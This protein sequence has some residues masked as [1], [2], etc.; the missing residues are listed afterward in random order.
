MTLEWLA[1]LSLGFNRAEYQ[2]GHFE[3][4][5]LEQVHERMRAIGRYVTF[6]ENPF[7]RVAGGGP[8]RGPRSPRT[9]FQQRVRGAGL[10][11]KRPRCGDVRRLGLFERCLYQAA[12]RSEE[13]HALFRMQAMLGEPARSRH[14][15]GAA[16]H[17]RA[18]SSADRPERHAREGIKG[19]VPRSRVPLG[20]LGHAC[21]AL[22]ARVLNDGG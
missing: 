20:I 2:L 22:A 7:N 17:S 15:R 18:S 11:L 8:G 12:G 9:G 10:V 6:L 13:K 5:G 3:E 14:L 19:A 4:D 21:G 1:L 16:A